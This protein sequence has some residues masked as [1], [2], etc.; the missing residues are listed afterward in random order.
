MKAKGAFAAVVVLCGLSFGAW[1]Q[2]P[3]Y[4]RSEAMIPARDG[5]KLHVVILRPKGSDAPG[6]PPLPFLMERTPYGV[7]GNTAALPF[8]P[9]QVSP[10]VG[11]HRGAADSSECK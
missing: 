11:Q 10:V 4:V 3:E 2:T 9:V 7:D 8:V 5:V 6:T 1:A